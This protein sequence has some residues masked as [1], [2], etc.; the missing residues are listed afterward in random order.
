MTTQCGVS[1]PCVG[2]TSFIVYGWY[3]FLEIYQL[4][5]RQCHKTTV[6]KAYKYRSPPNSR[7]HTGVPC[8]VKNVHTQQYTDQSTTYSNY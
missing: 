3:I 1:I 8:K 4:T 5:T 2:T 6:Y 7:G